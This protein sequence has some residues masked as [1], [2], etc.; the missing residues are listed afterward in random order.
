M[1]KK[2]LSKIFSILVILVLVFSF[3]ACKDEGTSEEPEE[4]DPSEDLAEEE[5]LPGTLAIAIHPDLEL[6][7]SNEED[8]EALYA[9]V[10]DKKLETMFDFYNNMIMFTAS[11]NFAAIPDIFRVETELFEIIS[12]NETL[13]EMEEELTAAYEDS[14]GVVSVTGLRAGA[15]DYEEIIPDEVQEYVPD[16]GCL[17]FF[18]RLME[19][20]E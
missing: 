2:N 11:P 7:Y 17:L 6:V 3:A 19:V 15:E 5:V 14:E 13:G 16:E 8:N 20:P 18:T 12:K 9:Y 4:T 1:T 10:S